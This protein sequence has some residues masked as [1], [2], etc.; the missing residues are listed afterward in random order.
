MPILCSMLTQCTSLRSPRE[1]SLFTRNLG[2]TNRLMP[3]T[4]SG[5]P[6]TRA[7]TRCTMFSAISCSP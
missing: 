1:P 6:V 3:F 7:S 2:T 5:A 4:P